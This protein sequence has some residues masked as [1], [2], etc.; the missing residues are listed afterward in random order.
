MPASVAVAC[1]HETGRRGREEEVRSPML[2]AVKNYLNLASGVTEV[3]RQRAVAAARALASSGEA[4]AEQVQNLADDLLVSSRNNRDAML[5]LVRYEVDRAL[6]RL[7]LATADEMASLQRRVTSLE[8]ALTT[9]GTEGA[10]K[11]TGPSRASATK[12]AAKAAPSTST[13][14][15]A[16][17]ARA[18]AA[19]ATAAKATP[20]KATN[21]APAKSTASKAT[22]TRT[23]AAKSPAK[24]TAARATAAKSTAA[25]STAAKSTA[26]KSTAS[27][28]ARKAPAKKSTGSGPTAS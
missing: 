26:S 1:R 22:A 28:A 7:G 21:A 4:T 6:N 19:K 15:K 16:T 17:A 14:G 23:A 12:S 9:S 8:G 27:K 2:D 20:A 25:K 5:A 24:A 13:P 11:T 18:T 10:A 3:T